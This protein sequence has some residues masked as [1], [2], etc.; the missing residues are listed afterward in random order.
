MHIK[1]A[2]EETKMVQLYHINFSG[3][4]YLPNVEIVTDSEVLMEKAIP[5][6]LGTDYAI[7]TKKNGIYKWIMKSAIVSIEIQNKGVNE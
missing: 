4:Q 2:K 1:N 7:L 5:G 6:V 3:R